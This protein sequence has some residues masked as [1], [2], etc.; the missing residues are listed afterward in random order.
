MSYDWSSVINAKGAP[1]NSG[2]SHVYEINSY[3]V[4]PTGLL[5]IYGGVNYWLPIARVQLSQ[6]MVADKYLAI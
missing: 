6:R 4:V 3:V 2:N 1:F 5:A